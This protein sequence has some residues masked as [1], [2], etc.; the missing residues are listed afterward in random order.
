MWMVLIYL[1]YLLQ[2]CA[3]NISESSFCS[4]AVA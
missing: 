4:I 2:R 3:Q 1:I